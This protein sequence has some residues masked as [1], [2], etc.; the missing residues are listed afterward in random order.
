MSETL[1]VVTLVVALLTFVA[2]LFRPT[3]RRFRFPCPHCDRGFNYLGDAI[4]H[5][6][7]DHPVVTPMFWEAHNAKRSWKGYE[8][9]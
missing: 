6:E 9:E 3:P 7:F 5:Q 2:L 4:R 8:G 1:S